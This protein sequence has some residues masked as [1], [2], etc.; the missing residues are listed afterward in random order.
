MA[1]HGHVYIQVCMLYASLPGLLVGLA[2]M[3]EVGLV[4]VG[5]CA[6]V[7]GLVVVWAGTGVAAQGGFINTA[8]RRPRG[9]HMYLEPSSLQVCAPCLA[10]T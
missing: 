9:G 2:G 8:M 7:L 1:D 6:G 4:S 3:W 5:G 10:V